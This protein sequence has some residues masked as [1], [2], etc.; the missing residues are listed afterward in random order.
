MELLCG[1]TAA[2]YFAGSVSIGTTVPRTNL[3][4]FQ[5]SAGPILTFENGKTSIG[6]GDI[7]G[8]INFFGNDTS[9][10]A[11]GVRARIRASNLGAS[12]TGAT[13]ISFAAAGS[14]STTLTD[15]L[16][17]TST[18]VSMTSASITDAT[19]G[20]ADIS[21]LNSRHALHGSY[22]QLPTDIDTDVDLTVVFGVAGPYTGTTNYLVYIPRIDVVGNYTANINTTAWND[23]FSKSWAQGVL[24]SGSVYQIVGA[25]LNHTAY[26]SNSSNFPAGAVNAGNALTL[27]DANGLKLRLKNRSSPAANSTTSWVYSLEYLNY[28][29]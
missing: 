9:A 10:N 29:G 13:Q 11:N 26:N 4:L 22:V 20:A 12:T 21:K 8:E 25:V 15:R 7:Y 27:A 1:G 23:H 2:N 6:S 5:A 18:G 16:V 3:N 14:G 17:L 28:Y 24:W 19:I